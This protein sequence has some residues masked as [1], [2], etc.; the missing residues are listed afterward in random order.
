MIKIM[1][2]THGCVTHKQGVATLYIAHLCY[3][4]LT[5]LAGGKALGDP[6]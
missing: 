6:V 5:K 2:S 4:E 3:K 1:E